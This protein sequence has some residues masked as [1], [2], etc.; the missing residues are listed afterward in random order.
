MSQIE[1]ASVF[2]LQAAALRKDLADQGTWLDSVPMANGP[3][4]PFANKL[5][6]D[7][8]RA[9][10]ELDSLAADSGSG[11]VLPQ[12]RFARIRENAINLFGEALTLRLVKSIRGE[13]VD[14]GMCGLADRLLAELGSAVALRVPHLSTLAESDFF[15][16][17]ARI[18]RLRYPAVSIWD[19][20]VLGHEFGHSFGPLW[21]LDGALQPYPQ[22]AFVKKKVLGSKSISEEYFC[23][24]IAVFLLGPAY[25]YMCLVLRFDPTN[26][27]DGDTHPSDARR[28]WWILR[29]L[30]L[31]ADQAD[32]ET[33][34]DYRATARRLK[35]FWVAYTCKSQGGR[36]LTDTDLLNSESEDLF[37]QLQL[38]IPTAAYT[39]PSGAWAL[40]HCYRHK[41]VSLPEIRLRD[42]L[43]ACWFLREGNLTDLENADRI[44]CWARTIGGQDI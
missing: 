15:G 8:Q 31:L 23:D 44:D 14:A 1:P 35:E 29:A 39:D 2:N 22:S 21:Y 12:T 11:T 38:A 17:S 5:R 9:I 10:S 24:L 4:A 6:L 34:A 25:A 41:E 18:V 28:A 30:E 13:N 33:G 37:A 27:E 26:D 7:I 16:T 42:L 3:Y 19:L 43:N 32:S 40:A 36:E 20:P